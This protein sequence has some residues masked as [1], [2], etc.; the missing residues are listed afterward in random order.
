MAI[1][2]AAPN[3]SAEELEVDL[4]SLSQGEKEGSIDFEVE[5]RFACAGRHITLDSFLCLIG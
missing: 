5:G 3:D 1:A 4:D 2:F